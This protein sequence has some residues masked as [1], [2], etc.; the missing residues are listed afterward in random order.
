MMKFYLMC[1]VL[2]LILIC[3]D[4]QLSLS[5]APCQAINIRDGRIIGGTNAV[6]GSMPFMASLTRRGGHYCGASIINEQWLVTAAHCV[7]TGFDE[8]MPP[9]RIRA[10]V[11]LHAISEFKH[12][13]DN[14]INDSFEKAYEIQFRN[15]VVHPNYECKRPD[16]DIALLELSQP[17]KF[18]KSVQPICISSN[19]K[20]KTYDNEAAFI[21]GWGNLD[22][23]F[24][25]GTR[26]DI[27]QIAE[28]RVWSNYECQASFDQQKKMK[29]IQS[30]QMCAGKRSG[31]V[32]ACWADS[33]GPMVSTGDDGLIGIVSTGIGCARPGL[34]GIYTRVSEYTQWIREI[35]LAN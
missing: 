30:T 34:P 14:T 24:N 15:I 1:E 6:R 4:A 33:G 9:H 3:A 18:S 35:V 20:N 21:S 23:E 19:G 29:T 7:C 5:S 17:I 31:G 22:E 28:V 11:G 25:I 13:D 16:N 27:L 26:P 12:K 8:I 32:D 10:I 2:V